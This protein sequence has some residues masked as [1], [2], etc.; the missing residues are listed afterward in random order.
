MFQSCSLPVAS[1]HQHP[2]SA[3]SGMQSYV[4]YKMAETPK[5][6]MIENQEISIFSASDLRIRSSSGATLPPRKRKLVSQ[7]HICCSNV[8]D[9]SKNASFETLPMRIQGCSACGLASILKQSLSPSLVHHAGHLNL[10]SLGRSGNDK[11]CDIL[12]H[13]RKMSKTIDIEVLKH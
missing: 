7:R 11:V 5:C 4:N 12:F 13:F 9:G 1:F 3:I 6:E 8:S 10:E 2:L